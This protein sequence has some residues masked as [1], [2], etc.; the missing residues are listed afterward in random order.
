VRH[1]T[2]KRSIDGVPRT[3]L[4]YPGEEA[5]SRPSPLVFVFHGFGG[6]AGEDWSGIARAWPEATVV[7]PHGLP[8]QFP[9][10]QVTAPGY[11]WVPGQFEDRDVRFVDALLDD[12]SATFRVDERRVYVA[13]ISNGALLTYVLMTMRPERFAAFAPVS[14][15]PVPSLKWSRVPRPVLIIHGRRGDF[16]LSLAEWARDQLLRVNGCNSE[17]VEWAPGALLYGPCGSQQ[18]VIVWLHERGHEWVPSSAEIVV[19]FFK[20]QALPGAA[21]ASASPAD[22]AAGI[23]AAGSGKA[24][25]SG[26]GGIAAAAQFCFPESVALDR[27]GNLFIADTANYRVR[28]VTPEGV[29]TTVAGTGLQSFDADPAPLAVNAHLTYPEAIALNA[30]GDL[31]IADTY[32]HLV[33]KVDPE[34][35]IRTVAG[36]TE[37]SFPTGL[38]VDGAGHLFMADSENHRVLRA[39]PDGALTA[40]AG[41]GTPGFSGD[42]GAATGARLNV[43][44][45][46][47]VDRRGNLFIADAA[48][49]RIRKVAPDGTITTVA[50][51]GT[52]GFSGDGGAATA[53]QLNQPSSM[54][55]DSRG[56][57]FIVDR[58]NHRVRQVGRTGTITTVF[59][60]EAG[61]EG[62]SAHA[63]PRFSPFSVAADR[64]GNLLIVDPFHHRVWKVAGIAAPGLVAGRPFSPL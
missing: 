55:I 1:R 20:E 60:G 40:A 11:Q 47:A 30:R 44:S 51:S 10:T 18:P 48:N 19:R 17:A 49:H 57:L 8:V 34:G 45:G 53:A 61:G 22:V 31:F 29:I 15:F 63:A 16:D 3:A 32:K 35:M 59:G 12:L 56:S 46:L 7:Y 6:R 33:R 21:P 26:D 39:A 41:T 64:E 28:R 13:G 23:A 9:G 5:T 50:G 4:V 52:A 38:A 43:P 37:L 2:W 54:A 42:G 36:P 25:F 27:A 58:L 14:G 62:T 24:G